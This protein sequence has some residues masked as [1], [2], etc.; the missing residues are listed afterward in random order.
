MER[1]GSCRHS[2][3]IV[4]GATIASGAARLLPGASGGLQDTE[5][6]VLRG[7]VPDD[8]DRQ[9]PEVRPPRARRERR[10]GSNQGGESNRGNFIETV[11]MGHVAGFNSEIDLE[12]F[13]SQWSE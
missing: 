13:L 8:G 2:A 3:R 12:T 9:D 6:L 5:A 10:T 4:R 7:P 1:A 11:T